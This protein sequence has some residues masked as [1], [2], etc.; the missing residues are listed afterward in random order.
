MLAIGALA[1]VPGLPFL[2]SDAAMFV[3][4]RHWAIFVGGLMIGAVLAR[5]R[6]RLGS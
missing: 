1:V 4:F 2:V 3:R 5:A 6:A